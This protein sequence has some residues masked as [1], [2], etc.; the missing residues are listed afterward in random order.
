MRRYLDLE[1]PGAPY[2]GQATHIVN[3]NVYVVNAATTTVYLTNDSYELYPRSALT[4]SVIYPY[5]FA[6][7]EFVGNPNEVIYV[8]TESAI[9]GGSITNGRIRAYGFYR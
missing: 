6:N 2:G 9:Y 3:V 7:V 4:T 1:I 5:P 8:R